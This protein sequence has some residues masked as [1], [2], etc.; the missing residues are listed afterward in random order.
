MPN[1]S[2]HLA[3]GILTGNNKLTRGNR[4][5]RSSRNLL[6][7]NSRGISFSSN[8]SNNHKPISAYTKPHRPLLTSTRPTSNEYNLYQS[9]IGNSYRTPTRG[10]SPSLN[11]RQSQLYAQISANTN[12]L[13]QM[14]RR[15]ATLPPENSKPL[16]EKFRYNYTANNVQTNKS[17]RKTRKQS[18]RSR[19]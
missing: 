10:K 18:R 15:I 17:T 1:A 16:L 6:S 14:E 11:T 5:Q 7:S 9:R 8:T 4:T 3:S 12:N 13:R 19:R 2:A